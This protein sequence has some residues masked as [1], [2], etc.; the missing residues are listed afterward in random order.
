MTRPTIPGT[1][2]GGEIVRGWIGPCEQWRYID[3]GTGVV[4]PNGQW[5]PA[6]VGATYWRDLSE[7]R[8]DPR[9]PEVAHRIADVLRAR[10]H[11][12]GALLPVALG[13]KGGKAFTRCGS[14]AGTGVL[15]A[16]SGGDEVPCLCGDGTNDVPA[17]LVSAV[18]LAACVAG[19]EC[20]RGVVR[21]VLGEWMH[22]HGGW[23]RKNHHG[24]V[25][26]RVADSGT[27]TLGRMCE[28]M[29]WYAYDTMTKGPE[30]G[31]EGR[32]AADAALLRLGFAYLD[33]SA[34]FGVRVPFNLENER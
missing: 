19:V 27:F 20:G 10:G 6:I 17:E 14:C 33:S 29:G 3:G 26:C 12:V 1:A 15:P 31:P 21:G 34:P 5:G 7:I 18:L 4:R 11:E 32:T 30:T 16:L 13:G 25:V 2:L 23:V 24:A 8:L 9:R 22:E 28:P